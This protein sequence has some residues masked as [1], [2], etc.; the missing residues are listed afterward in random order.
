VQTLAEITT[1]VE[2]TLLRLY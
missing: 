2:R 1:Y